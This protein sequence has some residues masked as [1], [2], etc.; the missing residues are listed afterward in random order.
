MTDVPSNPSSSTT[1]PAGLASPTSLSSNVAHKGASP[2]M[3][4]QQREMPSALQNNTLSEQ[5]PSSASSSHFPAA[6]NF[7]T[8][9]SHDG[10]PPSQP[11]PTDRDVVMG[12]PAMRSTIPAVDANNVP[13]SAIPQVRAGGAPARIYLNEKIVPYLLEGMKPLAKDQ[14]PNPLRLLG[15]YLIAKSLEVGE[16]SN[17]RISS[18]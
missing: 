7:T 16:P 8:A 3:D 18:T 2:I 6:P 5:L 15:E 11:T 1:Q 14:P 12:G 13:A 17:D 4:N 10:V 9:S